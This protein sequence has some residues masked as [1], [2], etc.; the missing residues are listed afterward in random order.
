MNS[1]EQSSGGQA[2]RA[3]GAGAQPQG[4]LPGPAEGRPDR[5]HRPFRLREILARLR[6]DLRRGPAPLRRVPLGL[7]AAVPRPD[8]QAGRGLHRGPVPRGL[9]RPEVDL[10]EPA[11]DRG[12]H[13]RGLR[14]PPAALRARGPG[15][16]P[17]VQADH[18]PAEPAADRRP[19]P[20]TRGG[21][22]LPGP[23]ARRPRAQGRVRRAVQGAAGQGVQPGPGGRRRDPARRA[24]DAQ[25]A[26]EA[27]RRGR[28]RPARGQGVGQAAAQRLDRD[29][30]AAGRRHD[31]ARLRGP[32]RGR[33]AARADVLRAPLLPV[34]R[35]VLRGARA[36]LVLLQLALRRLPGVHRPRHPDGGGRGA[37][38]PGSGDDAE[39]GGHRALVRLRTGQRLLRPP[40]RGPRP[41]AGLR[42][43]HAVQE[44][45]GQG[46]QGDPAGPQPQGDGQLHQPLR[47]HPQLLHRL[48]GRHP[49]DRAAARGG[50]VG[51]LPR[52][53]CR[54]H[55]RGALPGLQGHPA[56]AAGARRD[57]RRPHQGGVH[58]GRP[59]HRR[60]RRDAGGRVRR[61]PAQPQAEQARGADRRA[62]A[63]GG[64]RAAAVPG[65]R[66]PRLPL[67][68][69]RFG[70]PR[71]RRGAAHPAGHADRLGP[72]RR[73]LR[74]RRALDPS[75]PA[76]ASTAATWWSPGRSPTC[77]SPRSR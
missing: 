37:G 77:W 1:R 18:L 15:A 2:D 13:H 48:R 28:H 76:R 72:G 5:L 73:A 27:H 38:H 57:P 17:G 74:A 14:L 35:P 59:V 7:R 43:G 50:R 56:Q 63:Q 53:A 41:G 16:L 75:A 51:Q 25:E 12:H 36:A 67:A 4:H 29:G 64:Q 70:H 55:A 49:V 30:T 47:P 60:G 21:D 26:G 42:H 10:E 58:R 45:P 46:P 20:R 32:A 69:P 23:R 61:V 34:R 6:H 3:G 8:G 11:L 54:V 9:D 65:R 39:R 44:A 24:A 52:A 19:R 66:R 31:H 22:P 40:A 33:S 68:G 62:G 71:R